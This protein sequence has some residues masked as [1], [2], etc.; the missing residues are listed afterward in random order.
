MNAP[1]VV[2]FVIFC[3]DPRV[4]SYH[5]H[6]TPDRTLYH[7]GP[8]GRTVTSIAGVADTVTAPSGMLAAKPPSNASC[9]VVPSVA[10]QNTRSVLA[11]R[12]ALRIPNGIAGNSAGSHGGLFAG[13]GVVKFT[14]Y[15]VFAT[16]AMPVG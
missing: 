9:T 12:M 8:D 14:M 11:V 16:S 2:E 6:A 10:T 5:S 13:I 1:S 7:V 15:Q 3:T 4:L